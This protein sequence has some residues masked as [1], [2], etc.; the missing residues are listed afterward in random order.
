M[1]DEDNPRK[2]T[3]KVSARETAI[4]EAVKE[5]ELRAAV[6]EVSSWAAVY[7]I[8]DVT[9]SVKA[10]DILR[11]KAEKWRITTEHFAWAGNTNPFTVRERKEIIQEYVNRKARVKGKRFKELLIAEGLIKNHCACGQGST[12]NGKPL[13]L[14]LAHKDGDNRNNALSNLELICPNCYAQTF[15]PT[16]GLKTRRATMREQRYKELAMAGKVNGTST[17]I[18]H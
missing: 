3:K 11:A 7:R 15:S 4:A 13:S 9:R 8:F 10:Q 14:V 16:R 1:N 17:G 5:K 2:H 12:W 6:K 18:E